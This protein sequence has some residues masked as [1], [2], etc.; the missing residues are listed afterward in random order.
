MS[1]E[2]PSSGRPTG[3]PSGPLSGP[4]RPP[5]GP[6]P[7]P[8]GGD[9]GHG[10]GPGGGPGGGRGD[11]RGGGPGDGQGGGPGDG[12]GGG[13]GDGRG[14]GPPGAW[15][16]SAPR[17]AML[18][19]A[20]VVVAA[21]AVVLTRTAGSGGPGEVFL[22][23]AN[24]SGQDPFTRS[25]ATKTVSASAAPVASGA[26]TAPTN[27][28]RGVDGGAPGLYSGTKNSSSCDVEQ[29]IRYFQASPPRNQV[30]A[31][32]VGV[33]PAGVPAYLRSL[34]P[35]QLRAD[36]RV[37]G[38]G[39]RDGGA[40]TY[41]AVLQAGTAVLVDAHGVP[42]VRCACGNPLTPPVAQRTAPRTV[43]AA[44]P[45]YRPG[46]VVAV[47]PAAQ[48]VDVFVLFD[49]EHHDWFD[50]HRGDHTGQHDRPAKP[51]AHPNPMNPPASPSPST[52][53]SPGGGSNPPASNQSSPNA[54]SSQPPGSKPPS[55]SHSHTSESPKSESPKSESPSSK[56]QEPQSPQSGPPS[57]QSPKSEAPASESPASPPS[58][59]PESAVS[60][61]A[62]AS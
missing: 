60:P 26:A 10:G 2:P 30:F 55:S 47:A 4:S 33:Q 61:A 9:A 17:I 39:Y 37:T 20:V 38:H 50:R 19:T 45:G 54:P 58:P 36:T 28:V 41:Q 24:S 25:T 59:G 11:R 43:G 12:H 42:R 53:A 15:W 57:P 14:G 48:V 32:Q 44:W 46:D 6:P 1:V 3:P 62:P 56:S 16:R 31:A 8:P 29:Q 5:A 49:H 52:P 51:P 21:L 22:Q 13:S 27:E 40:T 35:V 34:T 18:T 7:Q 23:S